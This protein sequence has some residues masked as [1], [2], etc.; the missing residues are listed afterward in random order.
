MSTLGFVKDN[1]ICIRKRE[2]TKIEL[3]LKKKFSYL[4]LKKYPDE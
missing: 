4:F 1:T 3:F 2:K